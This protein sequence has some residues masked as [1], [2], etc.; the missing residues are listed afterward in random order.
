MTGKEV[1]LSLE[2]L[3]SLCRKN[4]YLELGK[5]HFISQNVPFITTQ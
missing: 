3:S 4:D 5:V 2:I 1:K